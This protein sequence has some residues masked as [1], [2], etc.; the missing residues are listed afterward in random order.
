MLLIISALLLALNF[1]LYRKNYFL[2]SNKFFSNIF[3]IALFFGGIVVISKLYDLFNISFIDKKIL[4]ILLLL[5][6][7]S[8]IL[9]YIHRVINSN[10]R[11]RL[12]NNNVHLPDIFNNKSISVVITIAISVVQLFIL[13]KNI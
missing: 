1:L 2:I 6:W 4:M 11:R 5:S 12:E 10:L 13:W 7:S 8:I 3:V 9:Y